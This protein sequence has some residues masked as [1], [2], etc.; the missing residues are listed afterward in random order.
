[1]EELYIDDK[2]RLY[3]EDIREPLFD[4]LEQVYGKIRF[5]EEKIIG[6][7][8]ADVIAIC[9]DCIVGVE[10][11]SDVDTYGRLKSQVKLQ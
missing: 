10:I 4:Y 5:F 9:C 3:D 7:S 2:I 1:M 6:K 8:I 11:K